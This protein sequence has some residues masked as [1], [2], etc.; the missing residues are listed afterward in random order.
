MA[1][2]DLSARFRRWRQKAR[3]VLPSVSSS[4]S[5]GWDAPFS[6]LIFHP[7]DTA[8]SSISWVGESVPQLCRFANPLP[9]RPLHNGRLFLRRTTTTRPRPRRAAALSWINIL[10]EWIQNRPAENIVPK[11][12]AVI[13]FNV[14]AVDS[15]LR[16]NKSGT[17]GPNFASSSYHGRHFLWRLLEKREGPKESEPR[18]ASSLSIFV[19]PVVDGADVG[20]FL[21]WLS[22]VA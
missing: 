9:H 15:L 7:S 5:S 3:V 17:E 13:M 16:S 14:T 11:A 20:A 22:W 19:V 21:D 4:P 6:W 12:R 2:K 18:D 1:S 10:L 8:A